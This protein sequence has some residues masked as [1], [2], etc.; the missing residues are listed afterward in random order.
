MNPLLAQ[1]NFGL[2]DDFHQE[3]RASLFETAVEMLSE[4]SPK[5]REFTR[6]DS[7]PDASHSVKEEGQIVMRQENRGQHFSSQIKMPNECSRMTPANR[8]ATKFVKR[9]LVV[10][11]ASVLDVQLAARGEGLAGAA[12]ARRQDAIKHIYG[13]KWP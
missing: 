12:V 7:L 5:F 1:Q 8:T 13:A 4:L 9:P 11:E 6:T 2:R 10:C 3:S